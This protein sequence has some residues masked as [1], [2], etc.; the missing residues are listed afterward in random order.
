MRKSI[1]VNIPEPCHEDWN[2]MSPKDK[3]RHCAACNKT[4]IDFTKQT[5]EQ[6]IK[7]LE[8]EGNL[9]GR[10]KKQQLDR[11]IV[12]ARKDRNNYL[13]WAAS[14]ILALTALG[15]QDLQAQGIARVVQ[16]DTIK[17]ILIKDKIPIS[18]LKD[19]IL[20]G[21]V[22]T[23]EDGLALPGATIQIKG[24]A[25]SC[26]SNFDG[27]YSIKVKTGDTITISYTGRKD[28][29]TKI[30]HVNHIDVA[31]KTN[32]LDEIIYLGYITTYEIKALKRKAKRQAKRKAIR[33][34]A[35]DRTAVGKFFF[36]IKS[37]F[38]KK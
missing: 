27:Y 5:D 18:I 38:S 16:T 24:S 23:A 1:T 25:K 19:K 17:N 35:Q 31:L 9:C 21:K 32:Y 15:S 30:N 3:G 10:F 2:K 6:I 33:N 29:E 7:Y 26:Q 28:F 4:V 12:L 22:T 13:S 8:S 20:T 37:L 14:G 11:E 34:G 36:R